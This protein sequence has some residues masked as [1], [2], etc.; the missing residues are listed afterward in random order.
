MKNTNKCAVKGLTKRGQAVVN[1]KSVSDKQWYERYFS[2]EYFDNK[3][4]L[5][6][7]ENSVYENTD[8]NSGLYVPT[9]E[10]STL[11][12]DLST[13]RSITMKLNYAKKYA[14]TLTANSD[15]EI[16]DENV[17]YQVILMAA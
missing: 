2:Q 17:S 13:Q 7:F 4:F 10:F 14:N 12:K 8:E 1:Q 6:M 11:K 16:T 5:E 15:D 3:L 9:F